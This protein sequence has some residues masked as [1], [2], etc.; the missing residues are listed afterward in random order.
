MGHV[1]DD[2]YISIIKIWKRL[3]QLNNSVFCLHRMLKKYK[4]VSKFIKA[5]FVRWAL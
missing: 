3:T 5:K 2:G 4:G 1:P